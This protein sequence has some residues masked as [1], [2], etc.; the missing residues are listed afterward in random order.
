MQGHR[1]GVWT[2]I[3]WTASLGL[4]VFP[5]LSREAG[6]LK[7]ALGSPGPSPLSLEAWVGM[8]VHSLV[9]QRC[10]PGSQRKQ[11]C[12]AMGRPDEN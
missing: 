6:C 7:A 9:P 4:A 3:L 1:H 2:L 8:E 10:P 12:I 5:G 11:L